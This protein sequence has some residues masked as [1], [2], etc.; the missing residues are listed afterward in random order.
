M[1]ILIVY[2][3]RYGT[4]KRYAQK[5]S[6][7]TDLPFINYEE[8][9]DLTDYDLV[10]HFGG[11]YAGGVM[12]LK[13]TVKALRDSAGLI[14]A[15]VGLAD[16]SDPENTARIRQSIQKQLPEALFRRTKMFHLRGGIDYQRL[17]LK[18]KTMMALLYHR[19]RHLPESQKTA[20]D[21]AMLETYQSRVDFVD[22]RSL[23]PLVE[24]IRKFA[25][26]E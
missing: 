15:T 12:G 26:P 1:R 20:E 7:L 17:S 5:C 4:T 16:V 14:V 13:H 11:L 24:E 19:V 9:T 23:Q 2:G 3:G 10:V 6:E 25:L 18:H 22:D 8:V 21:R